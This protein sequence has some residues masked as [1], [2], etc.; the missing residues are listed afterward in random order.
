MRRRRIAPARGLVLP[1]NPCW[2]ELI[3]EAERAERE[4]AVEEACED[5][6]RRRRRAAAGDE[7]AA[8]PVAGDAPE[9][10][11]REKSAVATAAP[12]AGAGLGWHSHFQEQRKLHTG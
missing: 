1:L 10:H 3:G 5:V 7:L 6:A 2:D 8:A 4:G 11:V 9:A 12:D